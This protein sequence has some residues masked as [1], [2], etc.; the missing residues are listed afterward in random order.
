MTEIF[1]DNVDITAL[2]DGE[3]WHILEAEVVLTKNS[4]PNYVDMR[5]T[6]SEE[7]DMVDVPQR[8]QSEGGLLGADFTLDVN[9]ELRVDTP[10]PEITRLFTGNLANMTPT[11]EYTFEAIAND[12][13]Q[14]PFIEGASSDSRNLQNT[15]ITV[16][17]PTPT[18]LWGG[19]TG[20]RLDVDPN[21]EVEPDR[22]MRVK[23]IVEKI[24]DRLQI[25]E[26]DRIINVERGGIDIGGGVTQ[27]YNIKIEFE[28]WKVNADKALTRAAEAS[29]S[30]WWFDRDGIFH[31]GPLIP[32]EDT[33]RY[34]VHFITDA[35]AGMTTPPYRS[36][37]VIGSGVA[38]EEGWTRSSLISEQRY[39]TGG[40]VYVDQS[41]ADLAPPTFTY[42][43][44]EISTASEA[45]N[46]RDD[47]IDKLND[48]RANGTVTLVG[49]PEIYPYDSIEMPSGPMGG[50]RYG[51]HT[52]THRLNSDDGFITKIEVEGLNAAQE[53]LYEGEDISDLESGLEESFNQ[54]RGNQ[55]PSQGGITE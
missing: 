6:P 43:N 3:E 23:R 41:D 55:V 45:D 28:S 39:S 50:E 53:A 40:N 7:V 48:Q 51:V 16:G 13:T 10:E 21:L 12:A 8:P 18:G 31:F 14:E 42:R 49:F 19:V 20:G 38:S 1:H 26:D 15:T 52:V 27:G 33:R 4:T 35:S 36:V 44:M 30:K 47:L 54:L 25:G 29:I 46:V 11:G 17:R 34:Q 24:C 2:I 32:N 9:T 37:K 22:S 5:L